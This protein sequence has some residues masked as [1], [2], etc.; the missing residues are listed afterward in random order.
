VWTLAWRGVF[1]YK[2]RVW[3]TLFGV[4]LG[5]FAF[6]TMGSM[7]VHFRR[8]SN[9]FQHYVSYKLFIR[10]RSGFLGGGALEEKE[11]LSLSADQKVDRVIPIVLARLHSHEIVVFGLP[12][13]VL[14]I[15]ISEIPSLLKD[16]PLLWGRYPQSNDE[17]LL[18]ANIAQED[19]DLQRSLF[20][21]DGQV[22]KVAG[23]MSRTNGQEDQ[24][25][26]LSL[27]TL[28]NLTGRNGIVSYGIVT[29]KPSISLDSLA[30]TIEAQHPHWE[31]IPPKLLFQN[32][33]KSE[34]LW[35]ALTAGTGLLAVIIGG[36]GILTIMMMAVQE[37]IKEIAILKSLGA[38]HLQIFFIFFLQSLLIS[39][40]GSLLGLSAGLLFVEKA[41]G[42]LAKQG[43]VLFEPTAGFL[44]TGFLLAIL[45]SLFGG[46]YPA[47]YG[48]RIRIAEA[49]HR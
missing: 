15:P 46:L 10:E 8:M 21:Y 38:G 16:V 34:I 48:S 44:G 19:P 27:S 36:I 7:A 47:L 25:A 6:T 2:F 49:L 18:G 40:I 9:R 17:C 14:G 30:S 3:L 4:A 33:Q 31:V 39:G 5:V 29:A 35:D 42:I 11:L 28:E 32:I 45:L 23:V 20:H 22:L 13:I 26:I 1:S 12:Q 41:N 37:Q 43:M 24:E